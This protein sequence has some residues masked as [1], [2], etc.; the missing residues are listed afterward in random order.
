VTTF[1]SHPDLLIDAVA[2]LL[3]EYAPSN[4]ST[5]DV[6]AAVA[7]SQVH[8]RDG[9][10]NLGLEMPPDDEYAVLVIGLARQELAVRR[11]ALR[12]TP[13]PQRMS[14]VAPPAPS[15]HELRNGPTELAPGWIVECSCGWSNGQVP[16]SSAD[17][18]RAQFEVHA[19]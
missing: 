3:S 1:T 15:T 14:E 7:R 12:T 4:L 5:P 6:L 9:F 16:A 11:D 10:G 17:Q 13:Q 2:N 8:V 18:A 19:R